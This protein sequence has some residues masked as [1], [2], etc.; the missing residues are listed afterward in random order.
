MYKCQRCQGDKI[1]TTFTACR[2]Y[3][4]SPVRVVSSVHETT[5]AG[6]RF[7]AC[8]NVQKSALPAMK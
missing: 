7:K 3:P 8:P 4:R 5:N 2:D 1:E 6:P